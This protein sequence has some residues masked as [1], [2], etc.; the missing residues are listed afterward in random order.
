LLSF[1]RT[2]RSVGRG[3]IQYVV[4]HCSQT[5]TDGGCSE[6]VITK[7]A[8]LRRR[9][10]FSTV[11]RQARMKEL[12]YLITL[13]LLGGFDAGYWCLLWYRIHPRVALA[14]VGDA[15]S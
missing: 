10:P 1:S 4:K 15:R 6:Q 9:F 3:R 11:M 14:G 8:S 5:M 13:L 12:L 7:R 2:F